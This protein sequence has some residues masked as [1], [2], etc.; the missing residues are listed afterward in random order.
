MPA[1][2]LASIFE[3]FNQVGDTMKNKW[4]GTGLVLSICRNLV[5]R[6]GGRIWAEQPSEGPGLRVVFEVPIDASELDS[7][8]STES[9]TGLSRGPVTWAPR[10]A[11]TIDRRP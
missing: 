2:D 7:Q 6:H 5:Q 11:K 8:P 10:V 1:A 9:E 3:K 4:D